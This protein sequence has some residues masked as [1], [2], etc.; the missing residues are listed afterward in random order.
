MKSDDLEEEEQGGE[1]LAKPQPITYKVIRLVQE[2]NRPN[3]IG[4]P[5]LSC[6][7]RRFLWS[8]INNLPEM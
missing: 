1:L 4:I 5:Q 8:G 7:R 2:I 6:V 3:R